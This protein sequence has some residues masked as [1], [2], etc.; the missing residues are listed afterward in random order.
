LPKV[1]FM[2][3][4]A[5]FLLVTVLA[6]FPL[7]LHL[8]SLPMMIWD[9]S[10][11][12]LSAFEMIQSGNYWVVTYL[13][14]PDMWS[15]KPPMTIWAIALSIKIFGFNELGLR[16]PSA[17]CGLFTVWLVF[18]FCL[19]QFKSEMTAFFAVLVLITT[20]G[21]I[22]C[23]VTRTGDYDS[24]LILFI[25]A[26]LLFFI[27]YYLEYNSKTKK[28]FL[29]LSA[30]TLSC[31]IMTK[32]IAGLFFMPAIFLFLLTQK[33]LLNVL[34]DKHF[35]YALLIFL[36]PL[37]IYFPY[38]EHLAKG[39][40]D[41]LWKME[42]FNRYTEGDGDPS[43]LNMAFIQNIEYYFGRMY[44]SKFNPWFYIIP[45][46]LISAN[47]L[48]RDSKKIALLL[49]INA[50]IFLT[51]ISFSNSKKGWY[52][53]PIYPYLSI[54]VG[55]GINWLYENFKDIKV[56]P[57]IRFP[58]FMSILFITLLFAFPYY[59]II[60]KI[61]IFEDNIYGWQSRQ[62][63]PF[64]LRVKDP[65]YFIL[66]T[67]YNPPIHI[68]QIALNNNQTEIGCISVR[69]SNFL[70]SKYP[71]GQKIMVCENEAKEVLNRLYNYKVLETYR[72][73][74]FVEIIDKK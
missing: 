51:I 42:L 62:Y 15:V 30:I 53:A 60:D 20:N 40:F 38:R 5:L 44:D 63:R 19:R 64:M 18:S 23:H 26:S 45:L 24:M 11:L 31:A 14:Q 3:R 12:A 74:V 34:K 68:T 70:T 71:K 65:R 17:L 37:L 47:L 48:K 27:Q 1:Q 10:R 29:Y 2:K 41:A 32:G 50:F 73:C 55:I 16:M 49:F 13:G 67:D 54:I 6:Y 56:L 35:Y 57:I 43:R 4:I 25:T 28:R 22:D 66:Q 58:I 72:E 8:E 69:D 59:R 39:Y 61:Y 7:F 36:T 46:G 52:D 9:E 21:Y 33:G